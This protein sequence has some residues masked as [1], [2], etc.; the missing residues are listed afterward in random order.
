M[1]SNHIQEVLD[2]A[3]QAFQQGEFKSAIKG[4]ETAQEF[5]QKEND[6]LNAA[7]MAN[8]L[9]VALLQIGKKKQALEAVRGTAD[10]FESHDD[11]KRQALALGNEAAA[12]E[13]LKHFDAAVPLCE[14]SGQILKE[15]GENELAAH[16]LKSLSL[17][18]VRKGKQIEGI[19]AMHQS[20][21]AEEKL[22]LWQRFYR[23][24]LEIPFKLS[25][26]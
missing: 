8:N 23:W 14:K 3:K 25:G 5:F 10:L 21:N 11:P 20:L 7:E 2:K 15:I 12:L 16:V 24:L 22:T 19:L 13:A 17:M 6:L 18:Q 4:F 9:S 1:E 26:R